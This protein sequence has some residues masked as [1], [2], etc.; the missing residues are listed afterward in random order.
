MSEESMTG[1][2]H[3]DAASVGF[4]NDL[5]VANGA[6]GLNN[7]RSPCFGSLLK[8]VLE[9]EKCIRCENAIFRSLTR[10]S[11]GDFHGLNATGLARPDTDRRR[12]L[13]HD[14]GVG[15]DLLANANGEFHA[16]ELVGR[17]LN[18]GNRGGFAPID[19]RG[20]FGLD[21]DTTFDGFADDL[22]FE[23]FKAV[24]R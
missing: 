3:G 12:S 8:T 7:G 17:W 10:T 21:Q 22:P 4:V 13:N 19:D 18:L 15:F 9:W 2:Q 14:D 5:L 1:E 23:R 6:A 16:V 11:C 24:A 20:F